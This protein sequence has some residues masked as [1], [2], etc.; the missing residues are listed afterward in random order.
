M[1]ACQNIVC[2][3]GKMASDGKTIDPETQLDAYWY[4]IDPEYTRKRRAKG[5]M[6]DRVELGAIER[7]M[8]YGYDTEQLDVGATCIANSGL[9]SCRWHPQV[10]HQAHSQ[11][12]CVRGHTYC[13][14]GA[15]DDHAGCGW[16]PQVPRASCL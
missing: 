10:L 9:G 8:A 1:L 2:Y 4:D 5:D 12:W 15:G 7:R 11:S 13:L 14:P 6:T 3:E 16:R